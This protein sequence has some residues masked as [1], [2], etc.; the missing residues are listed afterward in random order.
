[1][2]S[3]GLWLAAAGSLEMLG[4]NTF[5]YIWAAGLLFFGVNIVCMKALIVHHHWA[6]AL[7][8]DGSVRAE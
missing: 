1:M 7:R 4:F 8:E 6:P 3:Q 5:I 2:A